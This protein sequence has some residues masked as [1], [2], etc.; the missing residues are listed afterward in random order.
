MFDNL[1]LNIKWK[2]SVFFFCFFAI[3][4][5]L[6]RFLPKSANYLNWLKLIQIFLTEMKIV[7]QNRKKCNIHTF[8]TSDNYIWK[9][10][11]SI[12]IK[13]LIATQLNIILIKRII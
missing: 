11:H 9:V 8:N 3:I 10:S 13:V 1:F 2:E 5:L 6:D 12:L 7:E 4:F